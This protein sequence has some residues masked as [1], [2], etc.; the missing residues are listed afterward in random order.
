MSIRAVIVLHSGA[1]KNSN[2]AIFLSEAENFKSRN[3]HTTVVGGATFPKNI[4]AT[5]LKKVIA[6]TTAV[7]FFIIPY[8]VTCTTIIFPIQEHCAEIA[9]EYF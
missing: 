9:K 2:S 4:I 3:I 7:N 1:K 6:T 8:F 5:F